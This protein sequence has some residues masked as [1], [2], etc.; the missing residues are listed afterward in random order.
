MP[1]HKFYLVYS[2]LEDSFGENSG[3]RNV[4][5]FSMCSSIAEMEMSA[6]REYGKHIFTASKTQIVSN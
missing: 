4:T 6:L 1:S 3:T 2:A 5:H